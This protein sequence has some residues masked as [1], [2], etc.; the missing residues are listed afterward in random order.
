MRV[1]MTSSSHTKWLNDAACGLAQQMVFWG[2][3]VKHPGGNSL[4]RFGMTRSP[5]RGLAGTSCYTENWENGRI[6]LHGALASWT[7][8]EGG[9]GMVFSRDMGRID[10]WCGADPPVPGFERGFHGPPAERWAALLPFLRWLVEYERWV[11]EQCGEE[12]RMRCWRSLRRLPKGRPWLSP[13][14][15][16]LWWSLAST[17]HPPR[18]KDLPR[19]L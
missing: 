16:N 4:V 6:M 1:T 2:H 13:K 5:S 9:R 8:C 10:L 15:A 17:S 3:D 11:G 7:P 14:S 19:Y 18:C 12:W